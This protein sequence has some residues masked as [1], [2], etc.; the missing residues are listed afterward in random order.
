MKMRRKRV[1]LNPIAYDLGIYHIDIVKRG[2]MYHGVISINR[3]PK[4]YI[5]EPIGQVRYIVAY[6]WATDIIDKLQ[7]GEEVRTIKRPLSAIYE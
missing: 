5:V 6:A 4:S 7:K 2:E 1:H 3:I